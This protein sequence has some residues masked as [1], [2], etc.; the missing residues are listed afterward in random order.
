MI[1]ISSL[2]QMI[3]IPSDAE[4][5]VYTKDYYIDEEGKIYQEFPHSKVYEYGDLIIETASTKYIFHR[6]YSAYDY[7]AC[8]IRRILEQ[9][10]N[11]VIYINLDELNE[12]REFRAEDGFEVCAK[13]KT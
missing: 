8:M 5:T 4:F 2:F 10:E 13:F 1:M 7:C 3:S 9:K 12:A 6:V 11:P